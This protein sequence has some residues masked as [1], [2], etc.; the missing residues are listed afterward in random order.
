MFQLLAGKCLLIIISCS[1]VTNTLQVK[2]LLP[3]STTPYFFAIGQGLMII[4]VY[5]MGIH[6]YFQFVVKKIDNRDYC[7]NLKSSRSHVKHAQS[8]NC[9]M[10]MP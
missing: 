2:A 8:F 1:T 6:S 10:C 4:Y 3:V 5:K 9:I 7:Q